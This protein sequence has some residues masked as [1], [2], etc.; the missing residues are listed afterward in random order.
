MVAAHA[1]LNSNIRPGNPILSTMA[2]P[3]DLNNL[4][5]LAAINGEISRQAAMIAYID[6][7][8]MIMIICFVALPLLVFMRQP[9]RRLAE[10]TIHAAVE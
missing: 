8:K 6:A 2:R 9:K 4:A 5:S 3:I 7:F 10:E 1:D